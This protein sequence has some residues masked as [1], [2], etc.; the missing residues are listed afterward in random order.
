[1]PERTKD[2][3]YDTLSKAV[4]EI[5]VGETVF[6]GPVMRDAIIRRNVTLD[7]LERSDA[8]QRQATMVREANDMV[9]L[10]V[11]VESP[12]DAEV[13]SAAIRMKAPQE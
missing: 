7:E 8:I 3:E 13:P 6:R 9:L 10:R 1:L 5:D 11:V 4:R 2:L 12:T